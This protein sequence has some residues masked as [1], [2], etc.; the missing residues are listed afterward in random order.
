MNIEIAL[1]QEKKVFY[2][3]KHNIHYIFYYQNKKYLLREKINFKVSLIN[4]TKYFENLDNILYFDSKYMIKKFLSAQTLKKQKIKH[5][6]KI[7]KELK[8]NFW[9]KNLK[10]DSIDYMQ[11][12]ID[13]QKYLSLLKKYENDTFDKK[14]CHN[15]LRLK[16]I[17]IIKNAKKISII[18]YEWVRINDFYFDLAHLVLYCNFSVRQIKK[19]FSINTRKL[20]DFIY[21]VQIFNQH[22]EKNFYS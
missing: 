15:D 22:F 4:E 11:K 7:K 5:L 8:K 16:N 17:L 18:D 1:K 10:L 9:N 3:G 13:N 20:I 6:F 19:V 14:L 21:I 12:Q 2:K